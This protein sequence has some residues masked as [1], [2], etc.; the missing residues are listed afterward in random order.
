MRSMIHGGVAG[1]YEERA[2]DMVE[3]EVEGYRKA[4]PAS[5]S[6]P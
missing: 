2:S 3:S 4:S 6:K 1:T 5:A